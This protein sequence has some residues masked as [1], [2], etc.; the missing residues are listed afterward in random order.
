MAEQV[1]PNQ[2]SALSKK[3]QVA[4]MFDDI[5]ARYDFLNRLL[6][7][8]IDRGWR[9]KVRKALSALNHKYV[10]DVATGTADL[11]M[12]LTKIKDS[13]I[14]GVDISAGMLA[15]GDVKVAAAGLQNRIKLQLADS[16]QLPFKD[17]EFDAVTV[18]FGVRNFEHLRVGLAEMLRVIK[19]GGHLFI[20]EFSK[21][22]NLVF[23]GLYWFYFKTVLPAVGR[24]V[25]SSINAY[26]YL[27]R[28]VAAFPE[29]Q[30]FSTILQECGGK[31]VII[32]PLTFGVSTLYIC[33]K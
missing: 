20:L 8:G 29:G 11:A 33:E 17:G 1:K 4:Q 10:L 21:P 31:N 18:A 23:S 9:K 19:P 25:S 30:E 12:E 27:P 5:S 16:E 32:K 7:L 15:K 3:Q 26:S 14:I 22:K 13:N 28:S 24:L 6:S 2:D